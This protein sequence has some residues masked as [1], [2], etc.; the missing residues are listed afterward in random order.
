M[1]FWRQ[2]DTGSNP[3]SRAALILCEALAGLPSQTVPPEIAPRVNQEVVLWYR[4]LLAVNA[5][6]TILLLNQR[7]NALRLVVPVA[8]QMLQAAI[9]EANAEPAKYE[10]GRVVCWRRWR[11]H[12]EAE[13]GAA[14]FG[15]SRYSME[16][17]QA[18]PSPS[19]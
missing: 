4:R 13:E 3:L 11:P 12:L 9:T 10:E 16:S 18:E 2:S 7:I 5:K 15:C 6:R 1:A 8:V 14:G 19:S 17:P